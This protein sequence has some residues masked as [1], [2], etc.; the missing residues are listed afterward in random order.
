[1]SLVHI[2][3]S[4][5]DRLRSLL[6]LIILAALICLLLVVNYRSLQRVRSNSMHRLQDEVNRWALSTEYYLNERYSD[7]R[8]LAAN[9]LVT[10]FF[11]NRSLGMSMDYGLKASLNNVARTLRHYVQSIRLNGHS[12]Y[13]RLYLVDTEGSILTSASGFSRHELFVV[14]E[15]GDLEPGEVKV[16][17]HISGDISFTSPI[18]IRSQLQGYVVGWVSYD[19][20]ISIP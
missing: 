1:M 8:D 6:P 10:A 14:P 20:L 7:I 13:V 3:S 15:E 11:K 2:S 17:S 19:S 9:S 4:C 18:Y 12:V 16:D 5:P